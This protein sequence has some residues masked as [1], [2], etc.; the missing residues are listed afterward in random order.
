MAKWIEKVFDGFMNGFF[1]GCGVLTAL[2]L[3]GPSTT[4]N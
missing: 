2:W 3:L 4:G 1:F